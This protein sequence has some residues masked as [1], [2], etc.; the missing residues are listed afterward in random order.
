MDIPT[1][2][3]PALA[4]ADSKAIQ[5]MAAAC[6]TWGFFKLA[7]HGID[8]QTQ[9]RFLQSMAAFFALPKPDKKAVERSGENPWG[10]YDRELTKNRQ[11]WKEIF[12][13]GLEQPGGTHPSATPWPEAPDHF[14]QVMLDWYNRCET[15]AM[16][17]MSALCRSMDIPPD[18]L[19]PCFKPVNSSFLRLNYYP[20]CDEPA[21]A[22]ADFPESG[23]LGISHH[24][25]AG[26]VTV[27]LQGSVDGLQV[28]YLDEW[29]TVKSD[30]D[31]LIINIGDMIQVWSNDRYQAPLHR[32]LANTTEQRYS[33]AFFLNPD[34]AT[35][36]EPLIDQP[37]RYKKINWGEF[38]AARAAG[39]YANVG[40]E[41]QISRYLVR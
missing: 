38:R 21:D 14:R 12:D 32:V 27:L 39:D 22:A 28:R 25:D 31:S 41:I 13:L 35:W 8:R 1:L 19:L 9:A 3:L 33:A 15:I 17:L 7:D 18:S 24:T 11:D 40:E 26:A 10:Y 2:R 20:I 16:T 6:S 34:Y 29:I 4:R 23:H 30:P 36:C 5:E 37:A